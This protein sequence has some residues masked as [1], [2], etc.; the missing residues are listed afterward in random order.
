MLWNRAPA[1]PN[2]SSDGEVIRE[3]AAGI[4]A[5]QVP[6]DASAD[7]TDAG[8]ASPY[9]SSGVNKGPAHF[10]ITE[11]ATSTSV[12]ESRLSHD[13]TLYLHDLHFSAPGKP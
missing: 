6:A 5:A 1:T 2:H 11:A 9:F 8:K 12:Y 3:E 10:V 13:Y 4:A 7:Q